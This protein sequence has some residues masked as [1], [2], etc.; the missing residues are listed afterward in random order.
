MCE[1]DF[2]R[3]IS[4]KTFAIAGSLA[5]APSFLPSFRPSVLPSFRPFVRASFLPSLRLSQ[6]I[7]TC[8]TRVRV[9]NKNNIST[10]HWHW[11]TK[12]LWATL[13]GIDVPSLYN[14]LFTLRASRRG[15]D[16]ES[17]RENLSKVINFAIFSDAP[18]ARGHRELP[19]VKI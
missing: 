9:V 11:T 5:C 8:P 14:K 19:V 3:R 4:A 15:G 10:C 1:I 6:T 7:R 16:R 12:S 13:L 2:F 17:F 18:D